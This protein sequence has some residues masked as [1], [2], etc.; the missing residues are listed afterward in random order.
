[1]RQSLVASDPDTTV[2]GNLTGVGFTANSLHKV[3]DTA[4]KWP[5]VIS[6]DL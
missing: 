3:R 1:M 5:I 6:G 4:P 2:T